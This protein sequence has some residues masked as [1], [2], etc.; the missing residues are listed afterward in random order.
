MQVYDNSQI[1]KTNK[2]LSQGALIGYGH[3]KEAGTYSTSEVCP[4]AYW[5][6][7]LKRCWA[8]IRIFTAYNI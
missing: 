6:W 2:L 3:I 1:T 5:M 8:L 7:A 4:G